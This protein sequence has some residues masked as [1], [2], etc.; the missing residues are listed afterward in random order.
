MEHL[1]AV[2]LA[3][4]EGKRMKSKKTKILHEICGK[5]MVQWSYQSV[6]N[7]GVDDIVLVIGRNAEKVEKCMGNK[8]SYA[9]QKE[10]LGTGHAVIQAKEFLEGKEGQVLIMYG[11]MPL[12]SSDTISSAVDYHK[13]KDNAVTIIT[14]DFENPTGYGRIIRDSHKDVLKIVEDRDASSEQKKIK[15][16]NSGIYCFNISAL[17]EAL[18]ELNNENDQGEYYLTDTIE[19][20]INKGLRAGAIK[21]ENREELSGINDR[22]QL[23]DAGK[24]LRKRIQKKL[25]A[26][27]VTIIDPD[28][29]YID[30]EVEIGMDTVVYPSTVI[31]GETKIG[32]ECII[33]PGSRIVN[34]KVGNKVEI[35]ESVVL[36][37]SINDESKVGPFAYLRPRSDIGKNVKIGDFVEIKKSLIGDGTKISHLTYVGD[38][39]VGKKVNIG[40]GVVVVNYDGQN[41]H[42]TIIGDNSFIGCNVNLISPVVVKNN[43]YIAAGSTIT[44]EVP[45]N[46]LAIAR[47][48]QVIKENWVVKKGIL[49]KD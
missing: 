17:R 6:K 24:F 36:Q 31:E 40:C 25:M 8:V 41:K 21:I 43:A 4:G 7:A 33:G 26:G 42:K 29:T 16:I 14:A 38:A 48:R 18:K 13:Q 15:E 9:M 11:D 30:G 2:I 20:L 45:E 5:P 3:A 34:S 23:A 22:I 47:N 28:S 44:D 35:K 19:I 1:M 32:E 39:E 46:S 12:V 10:Q 27:G 49:K 37:S